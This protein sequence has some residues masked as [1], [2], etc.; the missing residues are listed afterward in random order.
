[1]KRVLSRPMF[2]IGGSAGTGITSGLDQPRKQYNQGSNPYVMGN[3]A[4]GTPSG[5]L[6]GFGLDLLSRPPAGNIFQTAALSARGPFRDFQ[7]SNLARAKSK[8]ERD[9]IM[10]ERKADQDFRSSENELNRQTQLD[11]AAM[12]TGDNN[13]LY[14]VML[15]QYV[16]DDLPPQVAERAAKFSTT[17]TDDLRNAVGGQRYGGVLTFDVRDPNMNKKQI[18]Q[19]DGKVVYDPFEDN[20]KYI[21][22]RDGEVYFDEFKTIGEITITTP[23]VET[24]QKKIEPVDPFSPNIEDIQGS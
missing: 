13:A 15:E 17:M 12:R 23:K 6:T 19:L 2:R 5:F 3:F 7:A 9:F 20:Y 10:S 22:I 11:I 1:M 24:E 4:P 14:N 18:K 16:E 8:A 21:V